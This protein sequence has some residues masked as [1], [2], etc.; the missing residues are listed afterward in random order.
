MLE[1]ELDQST[2]YKNAREMLK[3]LVISYYLYSF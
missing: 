3:S 2:T 1:E